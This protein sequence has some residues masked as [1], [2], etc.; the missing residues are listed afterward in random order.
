MCRFLKSHEFPEGR[1]RASNFTLMTKYLLSYRKIYFNEQLY[2]LFTYSS[3]W[4]EIA[5]VD[6]ISKWAWFSAILKTAEENSC[7]VGHMPHNDLVESVQQK[8]HSFFHD[9]IDIERT[10]WQ[11]FH[12]GLSHVLIWTRLIISYTL[13]VANTGYHNDHCGGAFITILLL[14]P[15]PSPLTLDEWMDM[16]YPLKGLHAVLIKRHFITRERL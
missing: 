9:F 4:N 6:S 13:A 16:E 2:I 1:A 3:V 15:R 7:Q 14:A 5:K 8:K 11:L 12:V 10:H